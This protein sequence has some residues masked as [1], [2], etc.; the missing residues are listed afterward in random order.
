MVVMSITPLISMQM[1]TRSS[2]GSSS[3]G[4]RARRHHFRCNVECT[5]KRS[6]SAELPHLLCK[7]KDRCNSTYDSSRFSPISSDLLEY[8]GCSIPYLSP[9]TKILC[10][11]VR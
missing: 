10:G 1:R 11:T 6:Q 9:L 4:E 7:R 2:R 5:P 8:D 3:D